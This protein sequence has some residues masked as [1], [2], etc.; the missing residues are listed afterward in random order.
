MCVMMNVI[1]NDEQ[2]RMPEGK[3]PISRIFAP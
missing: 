3:T 2:A 1:C